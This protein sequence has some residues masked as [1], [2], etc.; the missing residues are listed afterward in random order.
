MCTSASPRHVGGVGVALR[1][2]VR[3]M[4]RVGGRLRVAAAVAVRVPERGLVPV[5]VAD[6]VRVTDADDVRVGVRVEAELPVCDADG[7]AVTVVD[8]VPV[9]GIKGEEDSV[10]VPAKLLV[11]A[12]VANGVTD[13]CACAGGVPVVEDRGISQHTPSRISLHETSLSDAA[14]ASSPFHSTQSSQSFSVFGSPT[15]HQT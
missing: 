15:P 3:V 4:G 2:G 1:D 6:A 12:A 13:V 11:E 8:G 9:A 14:A 10:A 5:A 7:V